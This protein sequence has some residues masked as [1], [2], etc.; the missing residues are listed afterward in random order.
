MKQPLQAL[1]VP[2]ADPRD[3]MI[4]VGKYAFREGEALVLCDVAQS[5]CTLMSVT[6]V[7]YRKVAGTG[8]ISEAEWKE[9][10]Y[11]SLTDLVNDLKEAWNLPMVHATIE[12]TL[13]RWKPAGKDIIPDSGRLAQEP[14][15]VIIQIREE[16]GDWPD[17]YPEDQEAPELPELPVIEAELRVVEEEES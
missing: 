13:I 12:L 6:E 3:M 2:N 15:E 10:G 8:G 14:D 1:V 9:A 11:D 5:W 17:P 4:V 7:L 16:Q